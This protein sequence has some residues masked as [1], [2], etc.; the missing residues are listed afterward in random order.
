M[1]Y[2]VILGQTTPGIGAAIVSGVVNDGETINAGDVVN[3]NYTYIPINSISRLDASQMLGD[4][5]VGTLVKLNESGSPVQFYVAA[6]NYESGL[7]GPG[8]TLLVR[9]DV[10]QLEEW[11]ASGVYTYANSTI[12]TWLNETYLQL[13]D[14]GIQVAAGTTT[15]Y[16]TPMG[17]NTS[18][19]TI[20]RTIFALS[21]TEF[22]KSNTYANVEGSALPIAN[23]LK[24][25]YI[26]G[27]AHTQWTRTPNTPTSASVFTLGSGGTPSTGAA[28]LTSGY[29]PCLTLPSTLTVNDD[30]S[31]QP[32]S[33]P[34][35]D[36]PVGSVVKINESGSPV[37]YIVVNQGIPGNSPLY[38]QSCDGTWVLRQDIIAQGPWNSTNANTLPNSTIMTTMAG[39]LSLYDPGIQAVIK[40]VK[41]PYCVGNGIST[42]N[43]GA[44]G[45]ECKVFPLGAI[46]LGLTSAS[47]D[48]RIPKDGAKIDYFLS[49]SSGN[50][51]RKAA[52]NGNFSDW[53]TRSC[54]AD[55]SK[56]IWFINSAGEFSVGTLTGYYRPAFILPQ[57]LAVL[58]D[59]T[60]N[61]GPTQQI[62]TFT[63]QNTP[64]QAIAL[65]SGTSGQ[66]IQV[67]Y[68]GITNASWVTAGQTITSTTTGVQG[69]GVKDGMLEVFP[70]YRPQ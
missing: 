56:N 16:Y 4:V 65:S 59:G 17:G 3:V 43:S 40:T 10:Y 68:S 62:V 33:I 13:L 41:I 58:P 21:L 49:G 50:S 2:G 31:V 42:V 70:Y 39:Y 53:Y 6:Q 64:Y 46:E 60:I 45:L 34:L 32:Q 9:K 38:D 35:G 24:I 66:T 36:A 11:N 27:N 52:F 54:S 47:Y 29:R 18:V 12:D 69:Y 67:M 26:N 19:T 23:T 7:N 61:V 48:S 22:G 44:N 8:R 37:N 5:A 55:D 15:F 51:L 57:N 25:A 14:P 28:S 20:S 30:N 1:A 63:K